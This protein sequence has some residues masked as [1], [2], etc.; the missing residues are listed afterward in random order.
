MEGALFILFILAAIAIA[1]VVFA[2]WVFV[3]VIK[4][5]IHALVTPFKKAKAARLPPPV[6]HVPLPVRAKAAGEPVTCP[7]D[8]CRQ[9]NPAAAQFC[10]RCGMNLVEVRAYG[11]TRAGRELVA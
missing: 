2:V 6:R 11:R 4:A 8:N 9:I 5:L 7:R 10:R 1:M 3:M